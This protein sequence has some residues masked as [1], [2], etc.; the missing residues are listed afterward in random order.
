VDE[1]NAMMLRNFLMPLTGAL[2]AAIGVGAN[3]N[4]HIVL[5][6]TTFEAGVNFAAF[7]KV[8]HGCEG[9]PTLSLRI[10]IPKDVTVLELPPKEGWMTNAERAQ[11]RIAAIS[12][13]GLPKS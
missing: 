5:S 3:A 10:D 1:E 7:F 8:E 4:A 9:S 6:Q 2:V 11:G 12:W 13:R